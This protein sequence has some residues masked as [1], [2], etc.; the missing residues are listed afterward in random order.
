MSY[1]L[2][3]TAVVI[4]D[5]EHTE[6]F[7]IRLTQRL[8]TH[9]TCCSLTVFSALHNKRAKLLGVSLLRSTDWPQ[10]ES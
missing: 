9:L 6:I 10:G 8:Q 4:G 3:S 7:K 5:C 1:Q 2:D